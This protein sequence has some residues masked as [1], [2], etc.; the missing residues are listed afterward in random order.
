MTP[1]ESDVI[2]LEHVKSL[3]I[4]QT[5]REWKKQYFDPKVG[6]S[7]QPDLTN[8]GKLSYSITPASEAAQTS[9]LFFDFH[10]LQ[11]LGH[12]PSASIYELLYTCAKE[13]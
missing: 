6:D 7:W 12:I 11:A 1:S 10:L 8:P 3:V 4:Q 5:C 2:S 13:M 9:L